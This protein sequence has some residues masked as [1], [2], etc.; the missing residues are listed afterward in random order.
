MKNIVYLILSVLLVSACKK[1]EAPTANMVVTVAKT[2]YKVNDTVRFKLSGDVQNIVFYSGEV[3][4]RYD[5]V[6]SITLDVG[7]SILD[8]RI[9]TAG[10]ARPNSLKLLITNKL[11]V[12]NASSIMTADWTDITS[13]ATLATTSTIT[14]SGNID[15][16]DFYVPDKPVRIAFK[17]EAA[18][19]TTLAQPIWNMTGFNIKTSYTDGTSVSIASISNALWTAF[20]I[21]NPLA[22]WTISST[23]VR[24]DGGAKNSPDNED[25]VVTGPLN[26]KTTREL[27]DY[28]RSI[29]AITD[30]QVTQYEYVYTKPGTYKVTY[31]GFNNTID[32]EK[33]VVS[34]FTIN[35]TN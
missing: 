35:V 12:V 11:D 16:S 28:G 22:Q 17:Y 15:I 10:G 2:D 4:S 27:T 6:G 8:F 32:N 3:G 1:I 14:G 5:N 21:K 34:Q 33:K 24:I 13:R 19:S 20:D 18:T 29:K 31:V 7:S 26:L 25:W 23:Q 30:P 9:A